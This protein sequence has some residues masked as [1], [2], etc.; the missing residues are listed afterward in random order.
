MVTDFIILTKEDGELIAVR[1][2]IIESVNR[3]EDMTYIKTGD[4]EYIVTESVEE[5]IKL[6]GNCK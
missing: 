1:V 6:I 3:V 5:I 4:I 2:D